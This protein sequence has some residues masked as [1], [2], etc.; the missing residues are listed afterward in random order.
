MKKYPS[1]GVP[2]L[3]YMYPLR[4]IHLSERLHLTL[5]IEGKNMFIYYS[6]PIV[7]AYISEYIG[8]LNNFIL[9]GQRR[10]FTYPF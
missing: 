6:F 3:G 1:T 4:C 5:A 7:Y 8:R 2:K 10:P 9:G